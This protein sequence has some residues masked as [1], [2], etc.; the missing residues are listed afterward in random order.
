MVWG[1]VDLY[2]ISGDMVRPYPT[3]PTPYPTC[4]LGFLLV[5]GLMWQA[6]PGA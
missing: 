4:E 2:M 6:V 1:G 3:D 5:N